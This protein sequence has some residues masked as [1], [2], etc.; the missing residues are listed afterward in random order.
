MKMVLIKL[1]DIDYDYFKRFKLTG[2]GD[3]KHID[4][5]TD[6]IKNGIVVMDGD[7]DKLKSDFKWKDW[8]FVTQGP[9]R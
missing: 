3:G 7:E 6:A 9:L 5:V 2:I 8:D 4:A 1:S